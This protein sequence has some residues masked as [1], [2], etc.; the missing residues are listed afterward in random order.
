MK[1][2]YD[3]LNESKKNDQAPLKKRMSPFAIW[4]FSLSF[5]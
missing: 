3:S 1:N 5:L 2:R 4:T